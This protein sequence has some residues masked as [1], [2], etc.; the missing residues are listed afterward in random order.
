TTVALHAPSPPDAGMPDAGLADSGPDAP[1]AAGATPGDA[2]CAATPG[3]SHAA[4]AALLLAVAVR[5]R[6]R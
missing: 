3:R 5:R 6:R 2:G 4:W 1:P